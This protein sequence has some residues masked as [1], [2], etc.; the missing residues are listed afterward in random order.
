MHGLGYKSVATVA[1][2]IDNLVA[3]G[4]LEKSENEA[5]SITV[6]RDNI[7]NLSEK[8]KAAREFLIEKQDSF[9]KD[10]RTTEVAKIEDLIKLFWG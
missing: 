4:R 10:G 1:K 5:R 8:E 2:H 9:K 7:V 6:I 3:I